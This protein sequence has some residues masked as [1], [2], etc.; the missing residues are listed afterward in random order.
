MLMLYHYLLGAR[1]LHCTASHSIVIA[2]CSIIL[3]MMYRLRM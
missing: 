2:Y 1:T 3:K